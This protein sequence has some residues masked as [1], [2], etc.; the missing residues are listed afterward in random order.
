[1]VVK[2]SK[3]AKIKMLIIAV[4][5]LASALGILPLGDPIDTPLPI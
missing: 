1:M 3:A 5:L 4:M 2:M